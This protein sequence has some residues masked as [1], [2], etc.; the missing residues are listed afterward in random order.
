MLKEMRFDFSLE[1]CLKLVID[2][3]EFEKRGYLERDCS[4]LMLQFLFAY[5]LWLK[6]IHATG[7]S[8]STSKTT[9]QLLLTPEATGKDRESL[10]NALIY[11]DEARKEWLFLW[12]THCFQYVNPVLWDEF[13]V[14]KSQWYLEYYA[15]TP[16]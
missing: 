10:N 12:D 7:L 4:P 11:N 13:T 6:A 15:N 3:A 8:I 16:N 5:A 9:V 14:L 2:M 1:A